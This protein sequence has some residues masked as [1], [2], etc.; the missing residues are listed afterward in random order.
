MSRMTELLASCVDPTV[1]CD[2]TAE[3]LDS[4]LNAWLPL[5][6]GVVAVLVVCAVVLRLV[7]G[8]ERA[9]RAAARERAERAASTAT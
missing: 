8:P 5:I 2:D 3:I 1:Y 7:T 9:R 4:P 6:V